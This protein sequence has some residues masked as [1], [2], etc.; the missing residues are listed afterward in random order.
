MPTQ[1]SSLP[2]A[3]NSKA[4]PAPPR[5]PR[6]FFFVGDVSCALALGVVGGFLDAAIF[7]ALGLFTI[8][9]T[10]NIISIATRV[11]TGAP[12][13][14]H[15]V[16]IAAFIVGLA[17]S[18]ALNAALRR[19]GVGERAAVA[20]LF[21]IEAA[22]FSAAL[23]AG[24]AYGPALRTPGAVSIDS[25]P[26]YVVGSLSALAGAFHYPT[27]REHLPSVPLTT[28]A[29]GNFAA[30]CTDVSVLA[31][32]AAARACAGGC[33]GTRGGGHSGALAPRTAAPAGAINTSQR[34]ARLRPA[35]AALVGFLAGAFAGAWL[36]SVAGF[37]ALGVPIAIL[38]LLAGDALHARWRWGEA[39][40]PGEASRRPA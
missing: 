27:M 34:W 17:L 9:V 26:V 36:Q 14:S 38:L 12:A 10:G 1:P 15:V 37:P 16:V 40:P 35:A 7:Y 2:A 21:I 29:T 22:L 30:V 39:D 20:S 6:I 23:G 24:V 32:D 19:A 13:L 33:C 25:P 18:A 31:L 28:I 8:T 11:E 5:T 4:P 3:D